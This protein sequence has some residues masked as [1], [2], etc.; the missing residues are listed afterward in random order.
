MA[1]RFRSQDPCL[2]IRCQPAFSK[3][4]FH[5]STPTPFSLVA[6]FGAPSLPL[7]SGAQVLFGP[8]A[9]EVRPSLG[10]P[11][12][13]YETEHPNPNLIYPDLIELQVYMHVLCLQPTNIDCFAKNIGSTC[14]HTCALLPLM[15]ELGNC[16]H[17]RIRCPTQISKSAMILVIGKC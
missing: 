7:Y 3:F 2:P 14:V 9:G 11:F 17:D 5:R 6:T 12:L 1:P 13:L 8:F 10:L 4:F 16:M 15:L